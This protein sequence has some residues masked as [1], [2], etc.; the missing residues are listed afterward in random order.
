LKV[1]NHRKNQLSLFKNVH[2]I[3]PI[4]IFVCNRWGENFKINSKREQRE[5][6]GSY[7]IFEW[8][9]LCEKYASSAFY[10]LL[11]HYQM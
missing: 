6:R 11:Q 5:S 9:L 4:T 2:L 10:L 8:R 7:L 1:E 3:P